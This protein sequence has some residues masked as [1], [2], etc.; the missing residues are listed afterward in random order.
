MLFRSPGLAAVGAAGAVLLTLAVARAG[1]Q[2]EPSTLVLAG[3]VV[4]SLLGAATSLWL[5]RQSDS[6]RAV[7]SWSL[8]NLGQ[9]SWPALT[10]VAAGW[11]VGAGLLWSQARQLDA[12]QLGEATARSLGVQTDRLLMWVVAGTSIATAAA[13]SQAGLIGFVGLVAPHLCRQVGLTQHRWLLPGAALVGALLLVLADLGARVVWRPAELPV[14][15]VTTLL[16][17]PFFLWLLRSRAR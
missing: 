15:V 7:V 9:G 4:S 13:V 1:G 11:A 6:L 8:G 3:V 14:G 17:G 12:L 10:V 5:L 16:G 2:R